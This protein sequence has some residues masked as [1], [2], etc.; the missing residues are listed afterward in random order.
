MASFGVPRPT[1]TRFPM[2][3]F[4]NFFIS[5]FSV[6]NGE[7]PAWPEVKL[8]WWESEWDGWVSS[9]SPSWSTTAVAGLGSRWQCC[10]FS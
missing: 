5:L 10:G 4:K 7:R 6:F 9:Q 2:F 1:P 3:T 8:P